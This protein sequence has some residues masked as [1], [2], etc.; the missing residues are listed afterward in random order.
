V[1]HLFYIRHNDLLPPWATEIDFGHATSA[2]LYHWTDQPPVMGLVP[3]AWDNLHVWAP[4]VVQWG[5]VWWMFYAGVTETAGQFNDTQRIGAA[6]STD[7]MTWTRVLDQPVWSTQGVPWAWWAPTNPNMSCRDPF[8]MPD[9]KAPGQWLMYYTATPAS[10]T[11]ASLVAV[12]RSTG[13]PGMWRDEKPLWITYHT[14]TFN[15]V[16]ESPHLFQ[17]NGRWFMFI[18][19]NSG[20]PL[21]FYVGSDPLG[22]PPSWTYRGRL[23]NMLGYDTSDWYASEVLHDGDLDIFAVV[24]SD[25]IEFQ[26]IVWGSGDN[27]SLSEPLFFHMRS[28]GWTQPTVS[29]NR[30]VGLCLKSANGYAY[31]PP[32]VAWVKDANGAQIQAPMASL[33]IAD[34]PD[35]SSDSTVVRW[36]T[37]RWPTSLPAGQPMTVR[38]ATSDGTATT[39]WLT[40]YANPVDQPV[41][42]GPGG[43]LPDAPGQDPP[44][45]SPNPPPPPEDTLGLGAPTPIDQ[46]RL[47]VVVGSPLG[48]APAVVFALGA[49]SAAR[50]ELFDVQGRRLVT[51]ADR[52]FDAGTHAIAWDGRDASGV[53]APR[54]LYFVRLTTSAGVSTARFLLDH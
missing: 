34:T 51:L 17:H 19:T 3:G 37:R 49:A 16:T 24:A 9:P 52:G 7:L 6:V 44:V 35:L 39:P 5:G 50:V 15:W 10:D 42:S 18:T 4:H 14:Y 36:F 22:D 29:E 28:M 11:A 31:H 25:R 45:V 8:V 41:N 40:V 53:R 26:N 38:V 48:G 2:D 32:L 1:Y 12:A 43:A 46:A 47:R 27:F 23:S 21:T 54:G 20:Q 13:D 30:Y 33:G